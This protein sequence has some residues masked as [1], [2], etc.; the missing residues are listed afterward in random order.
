M[1]L[2]HLLSR[3]RA[4]KRKRKRRRPEVERGGGV[5]PRSERRKA[6][7]SEPERRRAPQDRAETLQKTCI[8]FRDRLK[9]TLKTAQRREAKKGKK[10]FESTQGRGSDSGEGERPGTGEK[11]DQS[12][13]RGLRIEES[14]QAR[15]GTGRMP[16][17]H[18]PKKDAASCEKPRGAASGH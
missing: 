10:K 7:E 4:R 9:R 1:R 8:V 6:S 17:R 16:R 18:L 14:D 13:R 11:A 2:D 5:R 3:E 12:G 15:K